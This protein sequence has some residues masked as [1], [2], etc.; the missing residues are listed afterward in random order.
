MK[1]SKRENDYRIIVNEAE[2]QAIA[3]G[4]RAGLHNADLATKDEDDDIHFQEAK[5]ELFL[6]AYNALKQYQNKYI[7]EG[8]IYALMHQ[9]EQFGKSVP[10]DLMQVMIAEIGRL[11]ILEEDKARKAIFGLIYNQYKEEYLQEH[12]KQSIEELRS[13]QKLNRK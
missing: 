1:I 13:K 9:T 3:F 12:T 4:V 10:Y 11:E 5:K 2:L 6:S 7:L 8:C